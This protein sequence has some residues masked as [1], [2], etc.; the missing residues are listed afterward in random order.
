MDSKRFDNWTRN[1]AQRLS[2]RDALRLAAAGSASTALATR[3]LHTFAQSTCS[4]VVHAETAGGP[5]APATY[6]G[7]LQFTLAGDGALT[8]ARFTS[9]GGSSSPAAGSL[10]GRALDL[11]ITLAPGQILALSGSTD[12]KGPVCP[13]TAAG[14]LAG[15]QPGDLGAWQATA[16]SSPS[17]PPSTSNQTSSSGGSASMASCPASQILCNGTCIDSAT[18]PENCGNCGIVCESGACSGGACG[19][20][21]SCTPDG[22]TCTVPADCCSGLCPHEAQSPGVC[23]CSQ[24]GG[25]CAGSDDC[26]QQGGD[27]LVACLGG[28]NSDRCIVLD[29][30][31]TSDFDCLN[32]NCVD[33]MCSSGC[34]PDGASCVSSTDCCAKVCSNGVCGCASLGQSCDDNTFPCCEGTP[35]ICLGAC[36]IINGFACSADADCC[37][38]IQGQGACTNGVCTR[39]T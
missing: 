17:V 25:V 33:G 23:G 19:D 29:G 16:E 35:V 10:I 26:C 3:S 20:S 18:D 39:T 7:M 5:S 36:C 28:T 24:I 9:A 22:G 12:Q 13:T 4:L 27:T 8:Q 14:I 32:Q 1:R 34:K 6:D 31:C 30:A 21:Q 15:P 2:R 37:D 11:S 38:Y